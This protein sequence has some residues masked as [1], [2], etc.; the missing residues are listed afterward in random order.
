[1]AIRSSLVIDRTLDGPNGPW[2]CQQP[3]G[4]AVLRRYSRTRYPPET[5]ELHVQWLHEFLAR[6]GVA[7]IATPKPLRL[8][9]D[10]SWVVADGTIWETLS[11]VPGQVVGWRGGRELEQVGAAIA[12]VHKAT[13]ALECSQRPGALPMT[14][15]KPLSCAD[16]AEF[17]AAELAQIPA[18]VRQRFAVH[19][20]PTA[21]NVVVDST[22]TACGLIDF[23]LACVEEGLA[24]LGACLIR[25][26]RPSQ[27]AATYDADR[28]ARIVRGYARVRAL[29]SQA[30]KALPLYM[31]ARHLQ[32]IVRLDLYNPDASRDFLLR[33]IKW[34]MDHRGDLEDWIG[35]VVID[36]KPQIDAVGL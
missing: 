35:N 8:L 13:E 20:D 27:E 34:L 23:T 4:H 19:G 14:E 6:L 12:R 25:S 36:A 21:F 10:S 11:F 26:G 33:R 28:I 15:C 9:N 2:L 24:D 31:L 30:A 5:S 22:G 1:M 32:M 7:G 18:P 29:G 17:V 3:D 16:T